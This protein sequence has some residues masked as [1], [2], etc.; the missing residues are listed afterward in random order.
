[1]I[2]KNKTTNELRQF[3][4]TG[5]NESDNIIVVITAQ[6]DDGHTIFVMN[7]DEFYLTYELYGDK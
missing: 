5:V 3:L 4:A 7:Y 2:Y 6:L 1:M